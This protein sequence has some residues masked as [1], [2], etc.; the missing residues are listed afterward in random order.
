M[1][2]KKYV[3]EYLEYCELERNLSQGTVKMY[4]FYLNDFMNW[5][6]SESKEGQLTVEVNKELIKKYRLSLNRSIS[7]K[8]NEEIKEIH[9]KELF[10]SV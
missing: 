10:S 9:P 3:T 5:I 7:N 1:E 8:S 4:H 2:L 6:A